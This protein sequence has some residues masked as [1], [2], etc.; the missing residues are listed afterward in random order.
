MGPQPPFP[1]PGYLSLTEEACTALSDP[2]LSR[3]L[4]ILDLN[5]TLLHRPDRM[6]VPKYGP[7][8]RPVHPRPYM[9]AFRSYLF[10]PETKSWLDVMVWSSAQPHSVADMVDKCFGEQ[11]G[12]LVAIWARDTLGLSDDQY[13]SKVQTLKDLSKPWSQL[14][15]LHSSLPFGQGLNAGPSAAL[16]DAPSKSVQVHS[17]LTTLLL[18]D[19]PLKAAK[20]PYNHV[21]IR[22][23]DAKRRAL[24]LESF[25]KE[26]DWEQILLT[27]KQLAEK[28]NPVDASQT[29]KPSG[30]ARNVLQEANDEDR[31]E[32]TDSHKFKKPKFE[33]K[34]SQLSTA[35]VEG[36]TR[37]EG[38][39]DL[40]LSNTSSEDLR[41]GDADRPKRQRYRKRQVRIEA[42]AQ[43]LHLQKPEVLYD[44][45]LL[46]VI[47]ILDQVRRQSNVAAWLRAGGLWGPVGRP[48]PIV[49]NDGMIVVEPV[50]SSNAGDAGEISAIAGA[51]GPMWFEYPAT[52]DS[53]ARRGRRALEGLGIPVEHGMVR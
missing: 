42:L 44:E 16:R 29:R 32:E 35:A 14:P 37:R 26:Q 7:R 5:G 22:E 12:D 30:G 18:D 31:L 24:D 39:V 52:M 4:L 47:G 38:V 41:Y 23:Y 40:P 10:T 49:G 13:N 1:T 3:K 9:A 27:R 34:R 8:L 17:A 33:N 11:R 19:S 36:S 50:G 45:T 48:G 28:K 53:W 20:Q 21:C 15:A 43:G 51:A 6:H 2:S 25:R 46:A